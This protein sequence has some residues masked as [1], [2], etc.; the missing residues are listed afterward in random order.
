MV[1]KSA[2]NTKNFGGWLVGLFAAVVVVA[3]FVGAVANTF[4]GTDHAQETANSQP[5]ATRAAVPEQPAKEPKAPPPEEKQPTVYPPLA[6]P[7]GVLMPASK[8]QCKSAIHW[9]YL[10][11]LG[12]D[13][14]GNLRWM[15]AKSTWQSSF[16]KERSDSRRH[17]RYNADSNAIGVS[18]S[19][20]QVIGVNVLA[21]DTWHHYEPRNQPPFA[22]PFIDPDTKTAA[23][24]V[25]VCSR[26]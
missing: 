5:A 17:L 16:G 1:L 22:P 4:G 2:S 21:G 10:S 14:Q 26:A 13:A 23:N 24:Q 9:L 7:D 15:S 11:G 19:G 6:A 20:V 25:V 3:G 12:T 8:D 18:D